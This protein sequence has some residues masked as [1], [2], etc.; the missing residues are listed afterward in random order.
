MNRKKLVL[1]MLITGGLL[2]PGA[3]ASSFKKLSQGQPILTKQAFQADNLAVSILHVMAR[4]ER[5]S[6]I[7][8]LKRP[9]FAFEQEELS[10]SVGPDFPM[11]EPQIK[12]REK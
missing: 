3:S 12:S 2:I 8:L 6:I 1:L 9:D 10:P 7:R 11:Y 5:E 4:L